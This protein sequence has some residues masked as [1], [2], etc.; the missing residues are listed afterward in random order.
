MRVSTV[1]EHTFVRHSGRAGLD[2]LRAAWTALVD[3]SE[4]RWFHHL[5]AWY[6]AYLN[7]LEADDSSVHFFAAYDA[8]ELLA[9]FPLKARRIRIGAVPVRALV[10]PHHDHM[11]LTDFVARGVANERALLSGLL[12]HL[13]ARNDLHWDVCY[14]PRSLEDSAV[15]RAARGRL[16]GCLRILR[17]VSDSVPLLPYDAFLQRLSKNFRGN[18]RKARN[19]LMAHESVEFSTARDI[20]ALHESFEQ[21]LEVEA[22]GWKGG[23][24]TGTAIRLHP[25]LRRFYL[26]LIDLFG[27]TG[28]CEIN[29]LRVDDKCI[30]AQFCIIVGPAYY[31]LKIGYDE[32]F[33]ALAPGNMLIEHLI[34]RLGNTEITSVNLVSGA[35]WHE[36]W[37]PDRANVCDVIIANRTMAGLSALAS[38]RAGVLVRKYALPTLVDVRRRLR[39]SPASQGKP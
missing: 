27:A 11:P 9:V 29:L 35:E 13:R 39:R 23:D 15:G 31:V 22:S 30:G 2:E 7:A 19:K 5:P 12:R 6:D 8:G 38:L 4:A 36:S 1:A 20:R 10:V 33:A 24:G 16:S 34:Q 25:D 18:L 21:F 17:G 37:R 28:A 26:S 14:F 32:E 3:D